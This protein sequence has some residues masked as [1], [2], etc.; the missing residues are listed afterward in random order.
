MR[1]YFA[2]VFVVILSLFFAKGLN[3]STQAVNSKSSVVEGNRAIIKFRPGTALNV[4]E[5]S[6]K[7]IDVLRKDKLKL[8]DTFVLT[9]PRSKTS[10]LIN[11]FAKDKNIEYV[12]EDH[13]AKALEVPNDPYYPQQWG[14]DK[15]KASLAFDVTHGSAGVNIAIVDTG[16][17]G[18]HPDLSSKISKAADCTLS[19]CE[20]VSSFDDNGHGTH[21]AGI[22]ASGTN[23]NI[24]IA[25]TGYNTSLIS[26]KVL[27]SSGSGYYSWVANGIIWAADHG[28]RVINLSLGGSSSSFTLSNAVD[29]AWG[30]GVVIVAASGNSN[31]SRRLYPAYYSQVISVAATD[32]N[33]QKAWFSSYGS[34]VKIA[35]PGVDIFS[36]YNNG[37][38][39]T[40]SGTSMATPFVSG[41]AG[42]VF[43]QHPDWTNTQVR[44]KLEASA[45]K[46]SGTGFY[47]KYGR[48][49]ACG[50][51]DCSTIVTPTPT[52]TPTP[53]ATPTSV[54]T[55]TS[56]P[57]PTV[58]PTSTPTPTLSPTPT[59]TPTLA[60]TPT[61]TPIPVPWW[62]IRWPFLCK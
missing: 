57:I 36:T 14:L 44:N 24:G 26:V 38:Y 56:T 8:A 31:S 62:C 1:K 4:Q 28:A 45:D 55:P 48:I 58:T 16:V 25:G 35:A 29:Y 18:D 50:A 59:A 13:V 5:S 7:N 49:N 34:W 52:P 33:D 32:Q 23:N 30:K 17:S 11:K 39:A 60:P 53:T 6:I 22:A 10:D 19:F 54:P 15:I 61:P 9:I 2:L 20:S 3:F 43:G 47:W 51:V 41:V 27:D 37:D 46:I 42:L 40:L 12:E 21:V